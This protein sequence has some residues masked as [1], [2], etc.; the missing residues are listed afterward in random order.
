MLCPSLYRTEHFSRESTGSGQQR[1]Q[2]GKV[3]AW[4]TGQNLVEGKSCY[5]CQTRET[6]LSKAE[7]FLTALGMSTLDV[8]GKC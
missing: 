3:D 1:G 6:G 7:A 5:L 4:K 8:S 2:K